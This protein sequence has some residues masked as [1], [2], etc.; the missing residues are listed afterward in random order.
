M[1]D[2]ILN[3]FYPSSNSTYPS[4]D[5]HKTIEAD[6]FHINTGGCYEF[7]RDGKKIAVYP[8]QYTI[9]EEIKENK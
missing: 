7:Y 3:I 8:I 2:Y 6:T 9:I 5:Y 4:K 1:N